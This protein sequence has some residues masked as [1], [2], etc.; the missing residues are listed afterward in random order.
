MG[1]W[2]IRNTFGGVFVPKSQVCD[3]AHMSVINHYKLSTALT[4][5]VVTRG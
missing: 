3:T 1:W 5:F 4:N 2:L